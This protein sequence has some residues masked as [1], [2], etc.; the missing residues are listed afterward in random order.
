MTLGT[1]SLLIH[2]SYV[3]LILWNI[4][5]SP[6]PNFLKTGFLT[7]LLRYRSSL[8]SE[9]KACVYACEIFS[10]V[11]WLIYSF[12]WKW[13]WSRSVVSDSLGPPGLQPIRLLHPWDFPGKSTEWVAISF[14]RGSSWPRDRTR[15]SCIVGRCFYRLSHPEVHEVQCIKFF[16]LHAIWVLLCTQ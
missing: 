9:H 14:S 7:F 6:L 11:L 1:F 3:Y 16:F 15:L 2:H 4:C 13:K 8:Y 12:S 10:P 5:S